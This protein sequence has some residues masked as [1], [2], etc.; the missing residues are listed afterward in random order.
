MHQVLLGSIF[1]AI[2][3]HQILISN[4]MVQVDCTIINKVY[5]PMNVNAK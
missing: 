1:P 2:H 3:H 4:L 5:I